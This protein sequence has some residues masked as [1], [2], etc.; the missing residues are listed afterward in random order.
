MSIETETGYPGG[1]TVDP[2][3]GFGAVSTGYAVDPLEH[4]PILRFPESIRVYD[5]MRR[6]D[7]QIG[8]FLTAA[9]SPILAARW[10]LVGDDVRP[11]V[12]DHVRAELGLTPPGQGRTRRRRQGIVWRRH[13]EEA[14]L[15]LPLGFSAFQQVYTIAPAT[16]E[17]AAAFGLTNVAHLR[18]L[19]PRLPGTV[20]K[21]HLSADGGLAGIS[22]DATFG[23]AGGRPVETFIPVE[24]LV[25]YCI[26][27]EGSDWSGVSILRNAYKDYKFKDNLVRLN[28]MIVERNGM[29]VPKVT[30]DPTV[31]TQESADR[32]GRNIRAGSQARITIPKG[33]A[34]VELMGVSGST[35]DPL[36]SISFH[37]QEMSKAALAMFLD[38]GHD[39]GARSLG[40]TFV[41]L[42]TNSLQQVADAIAE[43]ATEHI[44]RDLVELNFGPDEPYPVLTPGD[45]S[46]NR[47]I[48]AAVL[49]TLVDAGIVKP[50][51]NLEARVR[52]DY[53]LPF[54]DPETSR[55]VKPVPAAPVPGEGPGAG[56]GADP[57]LP[58]SEAG[59]GAAAHLSAAAALLDRI[60]ALDA[61]R[62]RRQG[63]NV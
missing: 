26:K 39:A 37:N 46:A 54:A 33:S 19:S 62:A 57:L 1:M 42:F 8:S 22:Q 41:D 50:D 44:I 59:S 12:V 14:L 61:A 55:D 48:S 45:L 28:A 31:I 35:V 3:Q 21:I 6:T 49:K 43:T 20:S 24:S 10:D 15:C 4:N 29:G 32:L 38:L 2:S 56:P 51:D 53:G 13:L 9:I 30:Y 34:D 40:D 25:F 60:D 36:P 16:P 52:A 27:R 7:G 23:T 63:G 47:S 18:K 5:E 17:E 58:L 11:E